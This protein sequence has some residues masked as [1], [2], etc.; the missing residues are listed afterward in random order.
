LSTVVASVPNDTASSRPSASELLE[1]SVREVLGWSRPAIG[2]LAHAQTSIT[3]RVGADSVTLLLDRR[4]PVLAPSPGA[5]EIEIE[6]DVDQARR[7]A[8]GA[9][10]LA[11][12]AVEGRFAWRGP[13]RKYL[14]VDPILR[15]LLAEL[16]T[17]ERP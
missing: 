8:T 14:G 13:I 9:L 5:S 15:A 2:R 10:P 3:F 6:L 1:R 12:A 16:H 4:P 17:R 11:C 7:F